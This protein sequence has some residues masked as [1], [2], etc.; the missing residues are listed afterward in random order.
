[1]KNKE[2]E[3]LMKKVCSVLVIAL[4]I[5]LAV[6]A[7]AKT[8]RYELQIGQTVQAG[9]AQLKPGAYQIEVEGNSLVFYQGQKEIAKAP[10]RSEEVTKKV[11]NTSV[12]LNQDKL[13]EVQLGGTKTKLIVE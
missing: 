6:T 8:K 7:M 12:T 10:V 5:F 1:M 4:S 2:I 9:G 13:V 11:D 3:Q